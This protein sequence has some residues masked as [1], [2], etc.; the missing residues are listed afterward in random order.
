MAKTVDSFLSDVKTRIIVPTAQEGYQP[1]DILSVADQLTQKEVVPLLISLRQDYFVTNSSVLM[2]EGID[3]YDIPYRAIGRTLR[4]LKLTD[5]S[6]TVTRNLGKIDIEDAHMFPAATTP[7]LYY[8]KGDKIVVVPGPDTTQSSLQIWWEMPPGKLTLLSTAARVVSTTATVVTVE[9][10]P[11]DFVAGY[12][13]DFIQGK[14][15]NTTM[16]IDKDILSISGTDITFPADTIPTDLAAGDYL[17]QAQYTPVVQLP[18]E[19]I[20]YLI[21]LTA[22]QLV[23][24][25]SDF[26]GSNIL[27]ADAD[28]EAK[29]LKM[30]LEPRNQGETTKIINRRSLLRGQRSRFRRGVI[31]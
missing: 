7:Y 26:E 21:T 5:S 27:R 31:F 1:S 28:R 2:T 15:G 8:I 30:L 22:A 17:A 29:A 4:D 14:S 6:E 20:P 16:A 3:T 13:V 11:I 19:V 18:N 25:I 10:V 12:T 9:S 24:G 23:Q